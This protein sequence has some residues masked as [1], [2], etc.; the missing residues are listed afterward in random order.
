MMNT[1]IRSVLTPDEND[2]LDPFFTTTRSY[3]AP[4]GEGILAEEPQEWI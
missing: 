2:R 1:W 4:L 3:F